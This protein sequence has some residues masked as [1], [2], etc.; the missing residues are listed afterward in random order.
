MAFLQPHS[1]PLHCSI[2]IFHSCL[3]PR[4]LV[5]DSHGII[6]GGT[7]HQALCSAGEALKSRLVV[8]DGSLKCLHAK[9]RE[10]IKV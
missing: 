5:V 7:V 9:M 6:C 10:S 1:P 4:Q 3:Q 2:E 8:S